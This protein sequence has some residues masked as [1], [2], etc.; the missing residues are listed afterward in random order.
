MITL[1]DI[2]NNR[3]VW[4]KEYF[5]A[6]KQFLWALKGDIDEIIA[7]GELIYKDWIDL[8]KTDKRLIDKVFWKKYWIKYLFGWKFIATW[9]IKEF[10]WKEEVTL[11]LP[12]LIK[13]PNVKQI[14][15]ETILKYFVKPLVKSWYISDKYYLVVST[16]LKVFPIWFNKNLW[17]IW[18][19]EEDIKKNNKKLVTAHTTWKQYWQI[20]TVWKISLE[21]VLEKEVQLW[22]VNKD[23]WD[24]NR[25]YAYSHSLRQTANYY[26]LSWTREVV[27]DWNKINVIAASKWSGKSFYAAKLCA[28]ELF[29]EWTWFW[30]R[31]IRQIKYFVPDL[32][33]VWSSVMDYMEWFL[34]DFTQKKLPNG[35]PIIEITSSKYLIKNNLTWATFRMVSLYNFGWAWA[36]WEWLACDFAVIDEAAYIPDEFW[37][38]F[39]QRALMETESMFIVTTISEKTPRDHWFYSLL[40]DWELW[41]SLISS[42][43]VDIL[44]KRELFE[45]NY[46]RW[47][48]VETEKDYIE[49]EKQLDKMMEFTIKDLKKAWL[50]EYYARAFCVILDESTVFNLTGNIVDWTDTWLEDYYILWVDFWGNQDPWSLVLTN[51][52]KHKVVETKEM[53]W[54]HYLDQLNEAKKYRDKYKN[55]IIVWDGTT[56]GKVIM[57]EDKERVIDYWVQFVWQWDWN[58]NNKWF[59]VSSKRHMVEMTQLLLDKWILKIQSN[60]FK[61]IEQMKN[62]VK[63]TWTRSLIDKYQGKGKTHDD[64]VDWLMMCCFAIVT[65]LWLRELK[66]LEDYW[67]EF[68]NQDTYEYN[69][70]NYVNTYENNYYSISTY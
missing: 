50:K 65:I 48:K 19:I 64:L 67:V 29:K 27:M 68:D 23:I 43:R 69:E 25:E 32:N 62:F 41:D 35:K 38:L 3:N 26:M 58:W 10:F 18:F 39:S 37:T 55:L 61:L 14:K 12:K 63:I 20:Q 9:L 8:D 17:V 22:Y 56:I 6:I 66:E 47:N 46:R 1:K 13:T 44:Q 36:T 57:Q 34:H 28:R 40:I 52:T 59:Y 15:S 60:L 42:H 49:M 70:S 33:N 45:L 31:K 54:I 5:T 51:I 16:I 2:K 4:S 24:P 53:M 30:W 11:M 21:E 7:S